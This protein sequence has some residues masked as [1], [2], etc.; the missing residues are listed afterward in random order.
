MRHE[1]ST[2]VISMHSSMLANIASR[3]PSL[4]DRMNWACTS[5]AHFTAM[6]DYPSLWWT[7]IELM[8]VKGDA[9]IVDVLKACA[10][11][12][13]PHIGPTATTS[14]ELC[15]KGNGTMMGM[16][17][18]FDLMVS[19]WHPTLTTRLSHLKCTLSDGWVW[20]EYEHI[21]HTLWPSSLSSLEVCGNDAI[22][23]TIPASLT[24]LTLT[25]PTGSTVSFPERRLPRLKELRIERDGDINIDTLPRSSR[26][27][28]LILSS[29]YGRLNI[30]PNPGQMYPR[31]QR[32]ELHNAPTGDVYRHL[33]Y[34]DNDE[35]RLKHCAITRSTPGADD[36]DDATMHSMNQLRFPNITTLDFSGYELIDD[37]IARMSS[38][39]TL[40]SLALS[41]TSISAF[42]LV[43][44]HRLTRL[45][46]LSLISCSIEVFSKKVLPN[47]TT[48]DLRNS[49]CDC[50]SG[51]R[52]DV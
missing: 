32:L 37:P 49:T 12:I 50:F 6:K 29:T 45:Q 9:S 36:A 23:A 11:Y 19:M 27:T 51:Y 21:M 39:S 48:L 25:Q 44:L 43:E 38:L 1:F 34:L 22:I 46:S 20:P 3:M 18:V 8:D 15:L 42:D 7:D 10:P 17:T 13:G 52:L 2:N 33:L 28:S 4:T 16:A 26:L 5:Q 41:H 47:L 14:A 30:D 35:S 40:R 31:L 24:S